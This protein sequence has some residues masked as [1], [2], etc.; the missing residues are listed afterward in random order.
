MD[1]TISELIAFVKRGRWHYHDRST[2]IYHCDR[3]YLEAQSL[4]DGKKYNEIILFPDK[5]GKL[6]YRQ[7]EFL[8]YG[9]PAR[10]IIENG[11][12]I[13]ENKINEFT[14]RIGEYSIAG[15]TDESIWIEIFPGK[16]LEIPID[17]LSAG[18]KKIALSGLWTGMFCEGDRIQLCQ[19]AGYDGN[20]R[21]LVVKNIVF[22]ARAVF[23]DN[24]TFLP[25][26]EF[27]EDG[28]VLGT[29]LWPI[30]LPIKGNRKWAGEKVVCA[31]RDNK[32]FKKRDDQKISS[33]DV[34][35]VSCNKDHLSVVGWN[36]LKVTPAYRNLWEN[37]EW[38][39][40][41][42]LSR[43]GR[44]WMQESEITIPVEVRN[45]KYENG[46]L[47]I[48][49]FYRQP[50]MDALP[51]GTQLCCKCAGLRKGRNGVHEIVV[52]TGKSM[53]SIPIQNI[54][55][56]IDSKKM[57]AVVKTL[58]KEKICFWIHKE[59]DG[60][61]S[62]LRKKLE[63]ERLEIHMLFCVQE[64]SGILCYTRDNL[65]LRWLPAEKAARAGKIPLR[66]LWKGLGERKDRAAKRLDNGNV[67]LID[68][69]QNEQ[70]YEV[71][72]TDGTRYRATPM[73]K[74]YT[75]FRG[76]NFYLAELHSK[77][78]LI[79][80]YS[81]TEYDCEKRDPIP[82]EIE[83]KQIERVLSFPYGKRRRT[84]HL[85]SWVYKAIR[86]ISTMD[87]HGNFAGLNLYRFEDE[88][89][90]CFKEYRELPGKADRDSAGKQL[91]YELLRDHGRT[92]Q[93]LIYLYALISKKRGSE[94]NFCEVYELIRLT[95]RAWLEEEGK[96]LAS[97][98]V[99]RA[100]EKID[101]A[102][103]IS[104]I[105][106]LNLIKSK[107]GDG[108]LE[109]V[110]KPLAVHL[111]RMLGISCGSTIHQE[112]LLKQW[113]ME[114]RK[115]DGLWRRLNQLSLRGE[116]DTGQEA[117]VFDG[118]LTPNQVGKLLDICYSLKMHTFWDKEL[119]LVVD[120]ILLSVG[121]LEECD[122]FYRK[123][124]SQKCITERLS[125]LGRILTPGA[126]KSISGSNLSQDEIS[127]L[128][129]LLMQSLQKDSVPLSLVTDTPIPISEM[130]RNLGSELCKN[131][132]KLVLSKI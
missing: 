47:H 74:M 81:E 126:G 21:K 84:L 83:E 65:T 10:E 75:D 6:R 120:S 45:T 113:I 4:P 31:S 63:K 15:V 89:P 114:K 24:N 60:W 25:I 27:L 52:R 68:T 46:A 42:M 13:D 11:L 76:V 131:F 41:D 112:L 82:I 59:E 128:H 39:V 124:Q 28:L 14:E 103:A 79:C 117:I 88:I 7:I 5:K 61:H 70:K 93:Q 87:D 19:D 109:Q 55:P 20:H 95:L 58:R 56:G 17:Y 115:K 18:E 43:D 132:C 97:G 36:S 32:F 101:V 23:G 8:R 106:L 111:A 96:F 108:T 44:R 130:E 92:S 127:T 26:R 119:E 107:T 67:S 77:G 71:L 38:L 33:G 125:I 2:A 57:S 35:L 69:W 53:L 98:L 94:L 9:Y 105:L 110:A 99:Q 64:A 54:L 102:P 3:N 51:C 91:D 22:G 37:A 122:M 16:L 49:V 100:T 72:K 12:P 30:V 29:E 121:C 86:S 50:D 66:A 62:G 34:M 129:N 123:T 40:D 78:D 80:L 85:S 104:A 48:W 116:K 90:E 1:G 73:E 118:Q